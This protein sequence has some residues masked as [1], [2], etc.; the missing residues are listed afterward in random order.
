MGVA[1][2]RTILC[3]FVDLEFFIVKKYKSHI[4]DNKK[5]KLIIIKR[6]RTV[7]QAELKY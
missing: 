3:I 2:H 7:E 4:S 1:F 6:H 5:I